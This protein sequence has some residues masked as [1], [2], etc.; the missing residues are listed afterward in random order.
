MIV[1]LQEVGYYRVNYDTDNWK[2]I[3]KQLLS[4]HS[5]VHTIN[6]AQIIDDALDLARAH[7]LDYHISLN[8]T[9]YL[10]NEKEFIPWEAALNAFSFLDRMLRRSSAY[11]L[12]KV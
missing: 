1:N 3:T 12:W 10:I 8:T 5:K 7:F 9:Q 4:N 2:L 6:R 11:G